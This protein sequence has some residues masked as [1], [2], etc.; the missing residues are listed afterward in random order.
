MTQQFNTC[1]LIQKARNQQETISGTKRND[2]GRRNETGFCGT[3]PTRLAIF[4]VKI[5]R[6]NRKLTFTQANSMNLIRDKPK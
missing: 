2:L 4:N 1:K 6:L 3:S 5:V